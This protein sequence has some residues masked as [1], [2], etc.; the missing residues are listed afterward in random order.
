MKIFFN[1]KHK[2]KNQRYATSAPAP[3]VNQCGKPSS[4]IEYLATDEGKIKR[5]AT[6]LTA[7]IEIELFLKFS[8]LSFQI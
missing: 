7:I 4:Q 8:Q 1:W 2:E 5:Q 3:Q 6:F